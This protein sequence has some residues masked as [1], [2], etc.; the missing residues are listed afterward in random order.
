M[1]KQEEKKKEEEERYLREEHLTAIRFTGSESLK[2]NP[3]SWSTLDFTKVLLED[4]R[5]F[6]PPPSLFYHLLKNCN[7]RN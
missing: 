4:W 2:L 1:I 7:F 5:I 6:P 3:S